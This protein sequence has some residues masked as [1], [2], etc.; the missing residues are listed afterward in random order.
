MTTKII[1][2]CGGQKNAEEKYTQ[3]SWGQFD[4]VYKNMLTKMTKD[5]KRNTTLAYFSLKRAGITQKH[6]VAVVASTPDENFRAI[7]GLAEGG[8]DKVSEILA[9]LAVADLTQYVETPL[10]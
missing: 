1:E 4:Y 7:K 8:L 6:S 2:A 5:E 3:F 10:K 9:Q